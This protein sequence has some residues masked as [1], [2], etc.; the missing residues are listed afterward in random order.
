MAAIL[1]GSI[2]SIADTSELQRES[3][4]QAFER[5]KLDWHWDRSEYL[6]MLQQ[7]GGRQRIESYAKTLG[8]DVDAEA[9][10]RSKSEIFQRLLREREVLPRAG[11]AETIAAAKKN[12]TQLGFVTTT[13]Q[14][15]VDSLLSA[16]SDRIDREAFGVVMDASKVE[17][18]KPAGD[19]YVLALKQLDE[20]AANCVAIE[21]NLSGLQAAQ[22]AGVKCVA[23]PNEN[24]AHHDFSA[25]DLQVK[26]LTF[27][28]LTAVI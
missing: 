3:F 27:D 26:T 19:A 18:S 14:E 15:N 6:K 28:Q 23:F 4:N 20:V 12:G 22:A 11:V 1:F 13:S 8:E 5:H 24:T 25:A 2:G 7:S 10:H 17:Q 16:L 21:D 9:V